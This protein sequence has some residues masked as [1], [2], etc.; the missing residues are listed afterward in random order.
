MMAEFDDIQNRSKQALSK[1]M[2]A[3]EISSKEYHKVSNMWL[4]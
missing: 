3:L 2:G 1:A 4:K